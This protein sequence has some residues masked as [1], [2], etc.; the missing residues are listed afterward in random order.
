MQ[1]SCN[2]ELEAFCILGRGLS[3]SFLCCRDVF[4][5][6]FDLLT[7]LPEPFFLL[8]QE[9]LIS[10]SWV[11]GRREVLVCAVLVLELITINLSGSGCNV[12]LF[13]SGGQLSHGG[14]V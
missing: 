2:G 9:Q 14:E 11:L 13:C 7:V 10:V 5:I 6:G 12:D 4:P 1:L 3:A 8:P